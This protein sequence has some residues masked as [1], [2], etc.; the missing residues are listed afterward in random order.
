VV[1][2]ESPAFQGG[3]ILLKPRLPAC[4]QSVTDSGCP[5]RLPG[6]RVTLV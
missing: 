6:S 5:E 3:F 4:H 2:A 1:P